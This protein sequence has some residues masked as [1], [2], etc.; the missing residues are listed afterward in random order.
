MNHL[1]R[2][3]RFNSVTKEETHTYI[4]IYTNKHNTLFC[5][6]QSNKKN[7]IHFQLNTSHLYIVHFNN[8]QMSYA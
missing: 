8:M 1:N 2:P 6:A 3:T 4:Q 5:V 7:I